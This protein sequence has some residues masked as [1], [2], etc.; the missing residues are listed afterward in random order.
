MRESQNSS[1]QLQFEKPRTR[2]WRVAVVLLAFVVAVMLYRR[3]G[4]WQ[5]PEQL[6]RWGAGYATAL[7]IVAV[8]AVSLTC[9]VTASH[10]L[11]LTPLLFAPHWSALIT[12]TGGVAGAAGGYAIAR[13][14]GG[15]WAARFRHG[16]AQRFLETHSSFLALFGL[17][18][19]PFCPHSFI[20]YAAGL[21]RIAFPRF[22]ATTFI[23]LAVKS[24]V[25][26]AAVQNTI[27]AGSASGV[28]SAPA[29][30]SLFAVAALA[31]VGHI[32]TRRYTSLQV[33]PETSAK[34]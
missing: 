29:V 7:V 8:M 28:L 19:A 24:Y 25:Y 5:S 34:A 10:F 21:A 18:L 14:V 26:A 33:T 22:I 12:T 32:L 17:R 3:G 20:N 16:R 1:G 23:A 13:F 2:A 31:I 27:G 4:V 15:A 30:L 11:I 6:Q 9:G